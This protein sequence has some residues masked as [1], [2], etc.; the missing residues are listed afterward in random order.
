MA[1]TLIV[2]SSYKATLDTSST[3]ANQVYTE[4]ALDQVVSSN[5][6]LI[7]DTYDEALASL[8]KGVCKVTTGTVPIV[9][10]GFWESGYDR[11]GTEPAATDEI[12]VLFVKAGQLIGQVDNHIEVVCGTTSMAMLTPGQACQLFFDHT[13]Q[14]ID[15]IELNAKYYDNGI[16]EIQCTVALIGA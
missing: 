6:G 8:T 7:T 14:G 15:E 9:S 11:I 1:N 13:T 5:T 16:D 10:E 12:Q 4:S 3:V 2:S